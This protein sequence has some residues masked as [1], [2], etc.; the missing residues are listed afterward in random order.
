MGG[1]GGDVGGVEWEGVIGWGLG[2]STSALV[3]AKTL[4]Q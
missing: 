1:V 4:L 3:Q 2:E